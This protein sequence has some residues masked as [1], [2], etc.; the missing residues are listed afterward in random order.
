MLQWVCCFVVV[1]WG[2]STTER[3][4]REGGCRPHF[5]IIFMSMTVTLAPHEY[6]IT[7]PCGNHILFTT[8][9]YCYRAFK[10]M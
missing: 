3:V 6:K 8:S 2:A 5:M 10:P 7:I 4:P 1:V 9:G